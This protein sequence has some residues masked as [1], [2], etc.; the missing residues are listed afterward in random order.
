[1]WGMWFVLLAIA[2]VF[3]TGGTVYFLRQLRLSL[4]SL[5]VSPRWAR[6]IRWLWIWLVTGLPAIVCIAI[7][8]SL[9][10]G[11]DT[12]PTYP[13]GWYFR[14]LLVYPFWL[15]VLVVFQ[16]VPFFI[17]SHGIRW[18]RRNS[19]LRVWEKRLHAVLPIVIIVFLGTYTVSRIA[20]EKSYLDV[21]HH[22]VETGGS[23]GSA[24]A[25]KPLRIGYIADLQQDEHTTAERA[26]EVVEKINTSNPD[27]IL[28]GGDWIT[29][30]LDYVEAAA[31]SAGTLRAPMGVFSVL[32]DHEHFAYIDHKQSADFVTKALGAKGV[33]IFDNA[34]QRFQHQG[35]TVAVAF[36]TYNYIVRASDDTIDSLVDRLQGADMSILV[37]HQ[38]DSHLA[39]RVKN[40]VDVVLSAHTHGGQVNL[41]VG[42]THLSTARVETPYVSGRYELG[43]TTVIVTSGIGFSV[44][45]FRYA[46]PATV[47]IIDVYL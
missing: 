39:S 18:L 21:R 5:G 44:A 27:I 31:L 12:F 46:S 23:T 43:N 11:S 7:V 38:L 9:V 1:M 4:Q 47:E 29:S 15:A 22:T 45:P 25:G 10:F 28:S 6:R 16:S 42:F 32:G 24:K 35:K 34:I 37:S 36:L 19:S 30:G 17:A 41:L 40:K 8:G 33:T 3:L 13:K 2:I 26:L 20:W 14:W